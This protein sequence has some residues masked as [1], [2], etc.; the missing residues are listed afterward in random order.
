VRRHLEGTARGA[1]YN[2]GRNV[3]VD[4]LIY[5]LL[6]CDPARGMPTPAEHDPGTARRR[7]RPL[8]AGPVFGLVRSA[9]P[10]DRGRPDSTVLDTPST[11][12]VKGAGGWVSVMPFIGWKG[13]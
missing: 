6:R 7:T 4:V 5:S 2:G 10:A 9:L 12:S 13:W 3:D 1:F 8:L 11:P